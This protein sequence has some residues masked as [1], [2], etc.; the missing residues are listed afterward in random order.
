MNWIEILVKIENFKYII[1]YALII[2]YV[3]WIIFTHKK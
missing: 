2:I 3:L 1:F